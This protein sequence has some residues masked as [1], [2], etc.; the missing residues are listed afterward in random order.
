MWI[1][2][3]G[4]I[5]ILTEVFLLPSHM[6]LSCQG[7]LKTAV[8]VMLYFLLHHNSNLCMDPTCP[9]IDSTQFLVYDWSEFYGGVENPIPPNA[10]KAIGKVLDLH[11]FVDSY[12]V[13]DNHTHRSCT[14][15]LIYLNNALFSLYSKK[16]S[17]WNHAH[18][19]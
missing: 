4:R 1:I 14:C 16:Q 7:Y 11:M 12:H 19:V 6:V 13:R 9:D 17:F 10:P 2:D 18:L 3:L 5:E 15:F 8:Q